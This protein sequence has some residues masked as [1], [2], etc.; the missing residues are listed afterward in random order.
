MN[1][2]EFVNKQKPC[3]YCLLI[4]HYLLT[5]TTNC[6]LPTATQYITYCSIH[7]TTDLTKYT[8][9]QTLIIK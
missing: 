7:T 2:L 3:E 5:T 9:I 1:T 4:T 8:L 6:N